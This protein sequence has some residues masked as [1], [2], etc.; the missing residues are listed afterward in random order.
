M[1]KIRRMLAGI[2]WVGLYG[3]LAVSPV[4]ILL[5]GARPPGREYWRDFSVALGYCGLALWLLQF[6]LTARFKTMK[7]PFG[8]DV[9]YQFHRQISLASFGLVLLHPVI[10]FAFSPPLLALLN[11][12]AAPW[13]ARAGI[14]GLALTAALILLSL[15]RRKWRIEYNRWRIWHGIL[16]VAAVSLSFAHVVLAG[17][18]LNTPWKRTLWITYSVFW[19]ALLLWVRVVKPAMMARDPYLVA[20]VKAERGGAVTLVLRRRRGQAPRFQ[21]GQFAWLTAGASPFADA[22]HPFS[23]STSA[24]DRQEI[25]FTIK[26]LG[27]FTRRVRDF[28]EG[29][30]VYLDGPFG[31]FSC[32]RHAHARGFLFVAGGIGITPLVSMLRT[33]ADRGDSRP[34]TLLYANRDWESVTFREELEELAGRMAVRL[35][36]VLEKPHAGWT[37][38]AG[39]VTEELIRRSL[40]PGLRPN[41]WESFLCGPPP[42]MNAVEPALRR[43]GLAAG[44]IHTERFNLV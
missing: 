4:L 25:G 6:V 20:R 38:E 35:V 15:F 33:L 40:P 39:Y 7:S 8:S 9:V 11:I 1:K 26:E 23:I 27:D 36:Y 42:M 43:A 3:L 21:P 29:D 13:R 32:D 5:V 2:L 18:Y 37:G 17:Y 10:L 28:R 34:V 24:E 30:R 44:D 22:E 16:A 14:A 19:V 31:A 41:E 12:P